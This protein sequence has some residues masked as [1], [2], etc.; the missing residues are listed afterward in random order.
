MHKRFI[1]LFLLIFSSLHMFPQRFQG[2]VL[3]GFNGSQVEGDLAR[4][5]HKM[6]FIGGAWIQTP[7]TENFFWGMELKYSQ[8]GSQI[9]PTVKNNYRYYIYN[10]NYI[11]M[12]VILGYHYKDIFSVFGGL[13]FNYL[14]DKWGEDNYGTDPTVLYAAVSEWELGM[15]AGIK[16]PFESMINRRWARN[17]FVDLRFQYSVL[18]IFGD[19]NPFFSYNYDYCQ[20]N[21][22]IST[23][24]YYRID[25]QRRSGLF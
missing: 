16:V 22:L 13:S 14:I 7:I 15:L 17:F 2:G 23:T 10:L 6:G 18:S 21:N 12:P 8:K 11:D 4:G 25:I 24:L 3:A 19:P 9:N 5:Y 20:F 1:L